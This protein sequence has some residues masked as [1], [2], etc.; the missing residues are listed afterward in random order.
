[1]IELEVEDKVKSK[2]DVLI[3]GELYGPCVKIRV[4]PVGGEDGVYMRF[5]TY[6]SPPK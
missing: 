4:S 2:F 1:M 3:D 5:C 6:S